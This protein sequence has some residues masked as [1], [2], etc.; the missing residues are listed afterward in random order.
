MMYVSLPSQRYFSG[1]VATNSEAMLRLVSTS[2][3]INAKLTWL[4]TDFR[5]RF[6]RLAP[7]PR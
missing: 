7:I 3:E 1:C 4:V 5:G 6:S 2:I